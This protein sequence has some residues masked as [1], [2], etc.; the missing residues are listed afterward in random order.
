MYLHLKQS[1]GLQGG[2]R[3]C[4]LGDVQGEVGSVRRGHVAAPIASLPITPLL[5]TVAQALRADTGFSMSK[6]GPLLTSPNPV[7]VH[8][9]RTGGTSAGSAP[10]DTQ[11]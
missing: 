4:P 1:G 2:G 8:P 9:G 3:G 5:P 7:W 11:R 10:L 6:A